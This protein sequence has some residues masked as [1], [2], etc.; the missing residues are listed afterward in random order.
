MP[1]HAVALFTSSTDWSSTARH[2]SRSLSPSVF[3][4]GR[5]S[6][7]HTTSDG[8]GAN[9]DIYFRTLSYHS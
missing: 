7:R 9:V 6:S 2:T 3:D 5:P 1:D 8:P 4:I